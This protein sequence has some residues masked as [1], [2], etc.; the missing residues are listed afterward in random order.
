MFVVALKVA[1]GAPREAWIFKKTEK[2]RET[3]P[4]CK[5]AGTLLAADLER[6]SVEDEAMLAVC[7]DLSKAYDTVK[8]DLLEFLLAGSGMP[9]E[10]WRPIMDMAK[11]PRRLEVLS[12]VAEWRDPMCGLVPGCATATRIMSVFLERLRRDLRSSCPGAMIRC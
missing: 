4:F 7:I 3:Q 9:P 10:V 11:A 12:A 1:A 8:L 5:C 6:A 2:K